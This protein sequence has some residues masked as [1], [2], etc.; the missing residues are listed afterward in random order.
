MCRSCRQHSGTLAEPGKTIETAYASTQ[1]H[2]TEAARG[3]GDESLE[4]AGSVRDG[5]RYRR[6]REAHVRWRC[7]A[8]R[9]EN[10]SRRTDTTRGCALDVEDED[11]L[12]LFS[13]QGYGNLGDSIIYV[14]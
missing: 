10:R 6:E 12:K 5:P 8:G 4:Q 9:N 7:R 3:A 14:C 11:S 13:C 2:V 1:A